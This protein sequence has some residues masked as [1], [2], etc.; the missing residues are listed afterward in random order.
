MTTDEHISNFL[1]DGQYRIAELSVSMDTI[2]D[3]G[4]YQY[5]ECFQWRLEIIMLMRIL[6]EGKWYIQDGF[7]HIQF[8]ST[9]DTWTEN[10]LVKEIE[11][12]RYYTNMNEMPYITFTAHYPQI[13][14]TIGGSGQVGS[15]ELP[16][17]NPGDVIFYNSESVPYADSI[18]P[19]GGHEDDETIEQY[20]SGR[21]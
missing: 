1:R 13:A 12:I 4:S 11:H 20:F 3:K 8:G 2:V 18:N 9:D 19:Y 7:N 15:A 21:I 16:S 10:D 6:Y 14:S 17:G 5:R